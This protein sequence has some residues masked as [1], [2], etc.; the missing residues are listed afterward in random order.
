M[1]FSEKPENRRFKT[2][3]DDYFLDAIDNYFQHGLPA[4]SCA[5]LLID[6]EYMSAWF[7][8]H[9]LLQPHD[10]WLNYYD[11]GKAIQR[12]KETI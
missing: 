8:A 3:I 2:T 1:K 11:L 9:R 12:F 10:I 5:M 7:K 6:G 4:G